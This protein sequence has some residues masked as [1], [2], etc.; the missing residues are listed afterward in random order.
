MED[1]FEKCGE[2]VALMLFGGLILWVF[3]LWMQIVGG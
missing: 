2:Y 1:V 3:Q